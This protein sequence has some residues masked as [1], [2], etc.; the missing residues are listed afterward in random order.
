[1]KIHFI[2]TISGPF[3]HFPR[4]LSKPLPSFKIP[5]HSQHNCDHHAPNDKIAVFPVQ[6]GQVIEIHSVNTHDKRQRDE[7]NGENGEYGHRVVQF[8]T[9]R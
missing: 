5:Q 1:M 9:H 6:F 8:R 3:A 4:R 7:N 2:I